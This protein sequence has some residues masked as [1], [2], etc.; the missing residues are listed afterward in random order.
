M[1]PVLHESTLRQAH[2]YLFDLK[3]DRYFGEPHVRSCV[4]R[5]MIWGNMDYRS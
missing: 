1:R 3:A 2:P 4:S 5:E